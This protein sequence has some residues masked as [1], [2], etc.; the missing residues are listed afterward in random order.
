MSVISEGIHNTGRLVRLLAVTALACA[1]ADF[2]GADGNGPPGIPRGAVETGRGMEMG[3]PDLSG[4]RLEKGANGGTLVY[5][6]WIAWRLYMGPTDNMDVQLTFN[7]WQHCLKGT[8]GHIHSSVC[9][10]L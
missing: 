3:S 8:H 7:C 2:A 4:G 9:S 6:K 5:V 10:L 1:T